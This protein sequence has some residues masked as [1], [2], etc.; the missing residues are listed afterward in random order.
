MRSALSILLLN[1][2]LFQRPYFPVG[3][4]HSS[5]VSREMQCMVSAS[6]GPL[7]V[8]G[9]HVVIT[10]S[11]GCSD[12]KMLRDTASSNVR[13][14]LTTQEQATF[15]QV[16]AVGSFQRQM[17]RVTSASAKLTWLWLVLTYSW[18]W[19]ATGSV[20]DENPAYISLLT[21]WP[22]ESYTHIY[23]DTYMMEYITQNTPIL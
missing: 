5:Q 13:T 21:S 1:F 12:G 7:L 17:V 4:P 16:L 18:A 22:G 15:F 2:S 6:S 10:K 11:S 19:L 23:T 20:S 9:V 14:Q 8:R 3:Q